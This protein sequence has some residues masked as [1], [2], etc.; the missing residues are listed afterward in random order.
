VINNPALSWVH[1]RLGVYEPFWPVRC[2]PSTATSFPA[3]G[4]RPAGF[5]VPNRPLPDCP[6]ADNILTIS[7]AACLGNDISGAPS[8]RDL[9]YLI[10]PFLRWP[11]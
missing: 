5:S 1:Y 8:T 3:S 6:P 4:P 9:A 2:F 10:T 7:F 11:P